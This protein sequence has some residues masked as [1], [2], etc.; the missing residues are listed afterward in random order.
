MQAVL[1]FAVA[2]VAL[3]GVVIFSEGEQASND[4]L[5]EVATLFTSPEEAGEFNVTVLPEGWS[6]YENK[7]YNFTLGVP[8]TLKMQDYSEGGGA[9]TFTFQDKQSRDGFQIFIVP[10]TESQITDERFRKDVPSGVFE[11]P[12]DIYIDGVQAT[13]FLST[14]AAMGPTVEVWFI[15]PEPGRGVQ[16]YLYEVTTY[17]DLLSLLSEVMQTWRF[18]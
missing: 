9:H 2:G 11:Q 1:L 5:E 14:N 3:L 13:M 4:S 17:R 12:T 18:L 16:S 15:Y 7:K 6:F 10:Y 8:G